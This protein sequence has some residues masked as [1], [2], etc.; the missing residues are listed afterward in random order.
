MRRLRR[1]TDEREEERTG[2]PAARPAPASALL[3]RADRE[4][5][6]RAFAADFTRVRI[7]KH[8]LALDLARMAWQA[9]HPGAA[10]AASSA[11]AAP[12]AREGETPEPQ[13]PHEA[14]PDTRA[15]LADAGFGASDPDRHEAQAWLTAAFSDHY[16]TD[17]F[18]SGHLISGSA[19]RTMCQ[20]FYD[21]NK[22]AIADACWE[23]AVADGMP[24]DNAAIVVLSFQSFLESR[25]P[26]LLLKTVHDC[27]NRDGLEVTNALGQTWMTYGDAHIGDSARMAELASKASHDAVQDVLDTGGTSRAEQALDLIPDL[28]RAAGGPF[29]PIASFSDDPAVWNPVLQRALNRSPADNDL[30]QMV[31]GNIVPMG[32]LKARQAAR[33][34]GEAAEGV[35]DS[36]TSIPD[37]LARWFGGLEREIERLYGYSP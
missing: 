9:R 35:W 24:P 31:K 4:R 33:A 10:P 3:A 37:D 21:A 32:T 26:S 22:S 1:E 25:A 34:V 18:A 13:A 15:G 16:L 27:Y 8:Q 19:G 6:E 12:S 14:G 5:F 36:I 28:A 2:A 7:P 20:S 11:G 17:A 29:Q 30:Y 23:C